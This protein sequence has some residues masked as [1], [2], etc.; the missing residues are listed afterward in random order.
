MKFKKIAVFYNEHKS[1]SG[2]CAR[3]VAA[4]LKKLRVR[5][6]LVPSEARGGWHKDAE[7]VIT[8]GG[9]GTVLHAARDMAGRD[10]PLLG[11]NS[12]SLGFLS[13]VEM[14][15]LEKVLRGVLKG[16]FTLQERTLLEATVFRGDRPATAAMPAFNDC[17]VRCAEPR[18]ITL[19]V[20]FGGGFTRE[21][22]CDGIIIATPSGSTAYSLSASGPIVHPAI[23]ALLLSPVCPHSLTQR[24]LVLPP[25][26][27]ISIAPRC[28]RSGIRTG[29]LMSL[30]GQVNR[31]LAPGEEVLLRRSGKRLQLLLPRG[32][33]YFEVLSR[34]LKWAE[35]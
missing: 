5:A 28:S 20:K 19:D 23:D 10:L 31:R 29:A 1:S 9:D 15:G 17:V 6:W 14:R 13:A 21:F 26:M 18:T 4:M 12:G 30:D 25:E 7:L 24:P 16:N 35:R 34:K 32:Y 2:G 22:F 27:E 33:D 11:V 8:V 3:L